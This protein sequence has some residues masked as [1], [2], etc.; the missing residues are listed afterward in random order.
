MGWP[1]RRSPPTARRPAL[2]FTDAPEEAEA[3]TLGVVP[4]SP[5]LPHPLFTA[6]HVAPDV[7]QAWLPRRNHISQLVLLAA[8]RG[9]DVREDYA[10]DEPTIHFVDNDS[11]MACLTKG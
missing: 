4:I 9:L 6:G 7:S 10:T 3:R 11:A 8:V 2:L 1:R 5:R